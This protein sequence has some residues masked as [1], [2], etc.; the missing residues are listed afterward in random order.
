M[1]QETYMKGLTNKNTGITGRTRKVDRKTETVFLLMLTFCE[2]YFL[3]PAP[4][5][6]TFSCSYIR[7]QWPSFVLWIEY[8]QIY[9]GGCS[10][11]QWGVAAWRGLAAAAA[12][13]PDSG[14][15]LQMR[16]LKRLVRPV[17][18]LTFAIKMF[19]TWQIHTDSIET[20]RTVPFCWQHFWV[21]AAYW[22]SVVSS[23]RALQILDSYS[24]SKASDIW[25]SKCYQGW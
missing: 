14:G 15:Q 4:S 9:M 22:D 13:A 6:Q 1:K 24:R 5:L 25:L 19:E 23:P 20:W 17:A 7:P 16:A 11:L 18:E 2:S 12:K 10:I 8:Q 21:A 3:D